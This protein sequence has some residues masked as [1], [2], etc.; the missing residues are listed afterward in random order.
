MNIESVWDEL[1]AAGVSGQAVLRQAL[2]GPHSARIYAAMEYP[3]EHRRL[4]LRVGRELGQR[5]RSWQG[6]GLMLNTLVFA[7]DPY[8]VYLTLGTG[9]AGF[10]GVFTHLA[11]DVSDHIAIAQDGPDAIERLEVR[12]DLWR[13][14]LRQ[15]GSN[16]LGVNVLRGLYGELWMIR[17]HLLIEHDPITVLSGWTGPQRA[18]QDFRLPHLWLEVKTTAEDRSLLDIS[19]AAQLD[20]EPE[21]PLF[22]A[23]LVLLAGDEGEGI[24]QMVSSIFAL[25]EHSPETQALLHQR[26]LEVG[27]SML[28][29][30]KYDSIRFTVGKM[31]LF[32]VMGAFPRFTKAM[33]PDGV[34]SLHY[35]I[36]VSGWT[37]HL[38]DPRTVF[39]RAGANL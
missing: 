21:L 15:R 11:R 36:D 12:L 25:F 29:G 26:L 7:D 6:E 17:E 22:L 16:A 10:D 9:S 28:D 35:T 14:F 23:H 2:G 24:V 34:A 33:L 4:M 13:N 32:E 19:S 30:E 39:V 3:G 27:F 37:S 5:V 20:P 31:S 8:H 1:R 18:P 38:R